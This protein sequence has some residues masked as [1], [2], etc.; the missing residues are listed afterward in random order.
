MKQILAFKNALVFML[1]NGLLKTHNPG[2][3]YLL[4]ALKLLFKANK[5]GKSYKVP[6]S[7]FYVEEIITCT[8]LYQD[9]V[10]WLCFSEQKDDA[11]I[12]VN[13]CNY[14]FTLPLIC[15]LAVCRTFAI[16]EACQTAHD[17]YKWCPAWQ[18]ESLN[19]PDSPP[20]P[21]FQLILRRHHL[22]EDTFRQLYAADTEAFRR[23]LV[24]QFVD[25]RKD[26][27][28]N[29]RDFFLHVFEK[30]MTPQSDMFM[31][32]ESQTLF[33]FPPK[34]K[35]P[36][37][38]YYLFGVLCGLALYNL[39]I[40]YL[41]FPLILFKKLLR[42]NPSL[43][44]MKEFE[45]VMAQS[46]QCI[47][48][49]YTPEVIE[50]LNTTFTVSWGGEVVELDPNE[51][52]KPVTNSNKKEF[53]KAFINYAFKTSVERVF[54]AFERGFFKVCDWKVVKLFQPQELQDVMMGQESWDW[55][56]F[57]QN[58]VYEGEYHADHPTIVAFWQ[59]FEELTEEQRK[60]FFVSKRLT[61]SL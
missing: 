47:L 10:V 51:K 19:L 48:E 53:V 37:K 14:P 3:R 29:R 6:L 23:E 16:K 59:V 35:V 40:I 27:N 25:D 49:E 52:G 24:V 21:V 11:T 39:N 60:G 22:V 34:P 50:S 20:A 7:T 26:T 57:K 46:F 55:E 38:Q 13:F 28:V 18:H 15:K 17:L 58:T 5:S 56:V 54:E 12:S 30:L 31:H 1:K 42:A 8:Q 61:I 2:V 32:N 4:E 33:W 36:E 9:I 41:P 44:D 45:P 43:D